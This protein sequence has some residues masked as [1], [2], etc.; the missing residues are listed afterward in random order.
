MQT[1]LREEL[2][3]HLFKLSEVL[4]LYSSGDPNFVNRA[5]QWLS[6]TESVLTKFRHSSVSLLATQRGLIVAAKDGYLDPELESGVRVS[7]RKVIRATASLCLARAESELRG[8]VDAIDR[9]LDPLRLKMAQ[10]IS[11]AS[12]NKPI[13]FPPT[14]PRTEWLKSVWNDLAINGD[15]KL[16]HT[17]LSAALSPID[18]FYLLD[19][20]LDNMLREGAYQDLV[21]S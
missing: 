7:T 11:V 2:L 1:V 15:T 16:M 20:L 6:K 4:D 14:E 9:R 3:V 17:Y 13:S 5:V 8:C 18:R 19:E 10:L 21:K 12:S